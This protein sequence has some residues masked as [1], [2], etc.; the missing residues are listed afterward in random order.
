MSTLRIE[1]IT[2]QTD[3]P[4]TAQADLKQGEVVSPPVPD[5]ANAD[6]DLISRMAH[7]EVLNI[8]GEEYDAEFD[9]SGQVLSATGQ[10][11]EGAIVVLRESSTARISSEFKKYIDIPQRHLVRVNDVFARTTTDRD[12]RFRFT[13]AKS[14]AMPKHWSNSWRGDVVAGHPQLGVGWT[15]L[16]SKRERQRVDSG[17][18]VA[19][20]P[21]ATITGEYLAPDRSPLSGAVVYLPGCELP[22]TRGIFGDNDL[23]MQASQLTPRVTTNDAGEFSIAGIPQGC[24]ATVIGADHRQWL[25]TS[26]V[27]ATDPDMPLGK[28]QQ[29]TRIGI[30]AVDV[31]QS[32]LALVADPGVESTGIV[33]DDQ[34]LAIQGAAVAESPRLHAKQVINCPL[35]K[36]QTASIKGRLVL[37]GAKPLAKARLGI[38]QAK[39]PPGN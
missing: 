38:V 22:S 30:G 29:S 18:I 9:V 21:T 27:A 5:S 10:P 39:R 35:G 23:D 11:V 3:L 20:R 24:L 15:R 14:P 25:S 37:E 19:L 26:V 36:E 32:P 13:G 31:Q 2:A 16:G 7:C 17:M 6:N 8:T 33:V 28:Q 4:S 34:G 12:G 1:F